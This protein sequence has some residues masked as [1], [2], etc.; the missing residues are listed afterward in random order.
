MVKESHMRKIGIIGVPSSAGARRSGQERAPQAFR[1]A[2]FIA[3]LHSAGFE[4]SDFGDLPEVPFHTDLQQPKAQNLQLVVDVARR[5]A[6]QVE[7]VVND[8]ALPIV[9]GGDCTITLGVV[10]GLI[11]QAPNLGLMYLDG[12][13]DLNTPDTTTSGIFD[14]MVIAHMTGKGV[15]TLTRLGSRYPLMAEE[16]I[17][18]YG[19]NIEAGGID[20]VEIEVLQQCEMIEYPISKIR[21]KVKELAREALSQLEDRSDSILVHFDVDVI[22]FEDFPAADL[23]HYHGLSF[24][25]AISALEVFT[26]SRKLAALVI[27]EF[28]A[29]R[30]VDGMLA[31]RLVNAVANALEGK[32]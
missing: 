27:T 1:G 29:D 23:P 18:L 25:E 22:D 19:Y 13:L 24:D 3:R 6:N 16:D 21:G 31:L 11:H 15:D 10:A 4:V 14:G 9:L 12:D 2:G 30:D 32:R 5:V 7:R 17:V 26:A 20:A 28:N 8:K